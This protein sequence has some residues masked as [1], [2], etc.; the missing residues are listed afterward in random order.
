MKLHYT[1]KFCGSTNELHGFWRWLFTP[2][3]GNKK[4]LKCSQCGAKRHYMTKKD[5]KWSMF[6]WYR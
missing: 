2:H 1:C 4:W 5:S 6:D 3:F